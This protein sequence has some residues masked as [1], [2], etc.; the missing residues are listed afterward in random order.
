MRGI[1]V[2]PYM[3]LIRITFSV[4][5]RK[6]IANVTSTKNMLMKYRQR[7]SMIVKLQ[8]YQNNERYFS[9][10]KKNIIRLGESF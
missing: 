4:W 2:M 1:N 8:F 5:C 10:L 7:I 3:N 9:G 6:E